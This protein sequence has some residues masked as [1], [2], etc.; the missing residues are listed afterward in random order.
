MPEASIT[1]TDD[2]NTGIIM[3]ALTNSLLKAGRMI[4]PYGHNGPKVHAVTYE[5]L[6]EQLEHI[7]Y[8]CLRDKDGEV[9]QARII[10]DT[11]AARARLRGQGKIGFSSQYIWIT[12]KDT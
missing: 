8:K 6:Y 3:D 12:S 7:G 10:N 2:G 5:Q 11:F 1:R 9:T 4:E